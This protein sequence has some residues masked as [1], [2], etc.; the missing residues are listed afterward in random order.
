MAVV[1]PQFSDLVYADL[2]KEV[3]VK[4]PHEMWE[5]LD[6]RGYRVTNEKV[7]LAALKWRAKNPNFR[8]P[9]P[10]PAPTPTPKKLTSSVQSGISTE[11]LSFVFWQSEHSGQAFEERFVDGDNE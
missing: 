8:E 6:Y 10:A 7:T 5:I 11:Q 9:E 4:S 1:P 2:V 3:G